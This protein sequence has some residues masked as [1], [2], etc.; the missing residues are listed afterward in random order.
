[1]GGPPVARRQLLEPLTK[2]T[3]IG[4]GGKPKAGTYTI[5]PRSGSP[6]IASLASAPGLPPARVKASVA[7]KGDRRVLSYDVGARPGQKVT[8]VELGASTDRALRTVT[9]GKGSV[10]FAPGAQDVGRHTIVARVELAGLARQQIDVAKFTVAKPR[11]PG[12][13]AKLKAARK[14]GTLTL[15]W[16]AAGGAARYVLVVTPRGGAEKSY[17]L[18]GKRRSAKLKVAATQAG[19]VA[20]HA[21]TQAGDAG[22]VA[23]ARFAATKKP[24]TRF[25]P[26][27]ELRRK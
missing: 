20:I 24:P 12:R 23:S 16:K 1:V 19:T 22:K 25:R 6:L 8:F 13:P 5:T 4:V 2:V 11:K 15:R 21:L 3:W 10:R 7:G 26:F 18:P 14:G 17:R 9:S 27:A